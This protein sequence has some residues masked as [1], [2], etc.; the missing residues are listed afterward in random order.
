MDYLVKLLT[1]ALSK[2][3]TREEV[4]DAFGYWKDGVLGFIIQ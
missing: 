2:F 3:K 4:L 1:R